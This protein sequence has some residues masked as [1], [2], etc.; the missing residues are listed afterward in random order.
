MTATASTLRP[1]RRRRIGRDA[2]LMR[3]LLVG[4]GVWLL[5]MFV[6]PLFT[7]LSKS[8]RSRDGNFVGVANY[9][10]YFETPALTSSIVNSVTVATISMLITIALAF[11]FAYAMTRS[12]IP[13]KQLFKAIALIPLLAPS[14]VPA[15]SFRYLFGNQGMLNWMMGSQ[16]IYGPI[17]IVMGEVFYCFPHAL[18][19][20]T[21]ALETADGRLF[22]AA[23]SLKASRLRIFFT[24]TL[25]SAKYGLVSAA[26]I[27]FTQVIT[28]FGIPKITGGQYN[29]LATDIYQQVVGQGNFS[30]GAV[31]GVILLVPA[32]FAFVVDR[33]IQRRHSVALTARAIPYAPKPAPRFDALMMTYCLIICALI[34]TI[35]AVSAFA[36]LVRYWPY[37]LELTLDHYDFDRVDERGWGAYTSSLKIAAWTMVIGT[38]IVFLTAYAVTKSKGAAALRGGVHLFSVMPLSVPGLVLGLAYIFFFVDPNNPLNFLY[39]TTAILV[40]SIIIHYFTVS[41]LVAVTALRQIDQEFEAVSA[42]LKVPLHRTFWRVTVP[43]CL[44][45]IL[46]VSIYFFVNAMTT[47]SAVVFLYSSETMPA[48]VSILN[49]DETGAIASAAAMGI[50]IVLT[51]GLVRLLHWSLVRGLLRRTQAWRVR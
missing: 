48:S 50:M 28:D 34:L 13:G 15:I 26:V 17:G 47:T 8:V 7:L 16:T 23:R 49:Q 24:V 43:V 25:P 14:M 22:E 40:I 5:V 6:V 41:Y 9:L 35:L 32:V 21:T 31:V 19:I 10:A 27:A 51:S 30:M 4:A 39:R 44:P 38:V 12:C 2:W 37:N 20:I 18:L 36:S 45:A 3:A 42:S 29:V 46:D 1:M 33:I 11:P